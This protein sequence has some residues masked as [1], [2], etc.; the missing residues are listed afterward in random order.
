MSSFE[1]NIFRSFQTT[2]HLMSLLTDILNIILSVINSKWST[3]TMVLDLE[4]ASETLLNDSHQISAFDSHL[5]CHLQDANFFPTIT[6][7]SLIVSSLHL[8][9]KKCLWKNVIY[10]CLL[11]YTCKKNIKRVTHSF[12][13]I[14]IR[15]SNG[16]I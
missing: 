8:I 5:R 4:H 3:N 10:H 7:I 13:N 16:Y 15:C 12:F 2:V 6:I 11:I 14:N 1:F 9:N